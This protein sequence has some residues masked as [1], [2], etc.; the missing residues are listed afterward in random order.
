VLSSDHETAGRVISAIVSAATN[1]RC[2]VT[3]TSSDEVVILGILG[4]LQVTR[5]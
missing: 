4:L 1:C 2:E 5:M 3:D